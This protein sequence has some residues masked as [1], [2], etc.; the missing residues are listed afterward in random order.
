MAKYSKKSPRFTKVSA[1]GKALATTAKD[2]DAVHDR[3]TGLVWSRRVL[4]N[5]DLPWNEAVRAPRA[6]KLCG[7]KG[8]RAP[9]IRELLS[10]VDYDRVSPAIDTRFFDSDGG[11]E[12]T[13]TKAR[14]PSGSA[15]LV[16]L[17]LGPS[18]RIYQGA[19]FRVRAVRAGQAF[20]F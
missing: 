18:A 6:I 4:P 20:G 12:W 13:S 5:G 2:W 9:T 10:I 17:G 3:E 16:L 19:R 14:A 7:K 8:W 1:D 15:W 11:W